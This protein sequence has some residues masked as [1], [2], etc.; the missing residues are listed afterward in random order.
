MHTTARIVSSSSNML[1]EQPRCL[2]CSS[3]LTMHGTS[4]FAMTWL[5]QATGNAFAYDSFYRLTYAVPRTDLPVFDPGTFAPPATVSPDPILD[6]QTAIDT[7]IGPLAEPSSAPTWAYDLVGN[8]TTEQQSG[9]GSVDYQSNMLDQY[10]TVAGIARRY[11]ANGNLRSDGAQTYVYDSLNRLV[12]VIG[13]SGG[14]LARYQHDALGRRVLCLAGGSAT[15]I[16]YNGPHAVT[17]YLNGNPLA[18]IVYDDMLD[19]ALHL[20]TGNQDYWYHLDPN[21]SVRG[22]TDLTGQATSSYEYTPFGVLQQSSGPYNP[23]RFTG[24]RFDGTIGSYDFRSRQYDPATGRFLQRDPSGI[25]DGTNLYVY[26][27]RFGSFSIRLDFG[28]PRHRSPTACQSPK[29]LR[30]AKRRGYARTLPYT[31]RERRHHA[32]HRPLTGAGRWPL[33]LWRWNCSIT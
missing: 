10:E 21:R 15:H 8:R 6:T 7:T 22:L 33:T 9:G 1:W 13:P 25:R 17:D 12:R 31:C 23:L 26:A 27:G 14:E 18:Q 24:R 29:R 16:A 19:A 2:P 3:S 32:A 20:A 4:A 5:Q 11:D 28:T 30:R